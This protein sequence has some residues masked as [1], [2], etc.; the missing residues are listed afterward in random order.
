[1]DVLL[2]QSSGDLL[3]VTVLKH[4]AARKNR[5]RPKSSGM[6]FRPCLSML[7]QMF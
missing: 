2:A 5:I 6:A 1:M 3:Q 4:K 7:D